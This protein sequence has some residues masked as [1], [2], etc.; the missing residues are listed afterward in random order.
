MGDVSL[1][2]VVR[3]LLQCLVVVS[4]IVAIGGHWAFVQSVAWVGMTLSYSKTDS[5]L[6]ALQKT[7][8]GQHPC[9]L[10]KIVDEGKKEEQKHGTF[11]VEHLEFLQLVTTLAVYPLVVHDQASCDP[12]EFTALSASPPKPPPRAA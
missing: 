1:K 6:V 2:A 4:L 5:L 3:R 8:S 7:L 12:S 11:K 10:C 9:K